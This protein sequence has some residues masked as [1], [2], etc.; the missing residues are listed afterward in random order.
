MKNLRHR[1]GQVALL[2]LLSG[3]MTGCSTFI[4]QRQVAAR[5]DYGSGK[6]FKPVVA[7]TRFDNKSGFSGQWD[8][9]TGMA[10]VLTTE[11][12]ESGQYVV[13]ERRELDSV[14]GEILRQGQEFFRREGRVNQGRL[15]NVRYL[16]SGA[17]TDFTVTGDSSGW[18]GYSTTVKAGGGTSRA[19]VSLHLRLTDVESGEVISSVEAAGTAS[20]GWFSA[21]V[22][23]KNLAFGGDSF[24]RT[25]LGK[26]TTRAVGRAVKQ[27]AEA[28]P[29]EYWY[30]RVAEAGPDMVVLNGGENVGVRAGDVFVVREQGRDITDPVTGDV[31]ERLPGK[32]IGRIRVDEVQPLAAHALIIEGSAFRGAYLE[33]SQ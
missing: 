19:R 16:I 32:V 28:I 1:A 15:K 33:A 13:L 21:A 7:V 23:Y 31:I 11:L 26:A 24:F 25:P 3:W 27:L 14:L 4:E 2:L 30:P 9:G 8:L 29:R 12:L 5:P 6:R 17:I 20:A 18:F 10:D 22:S